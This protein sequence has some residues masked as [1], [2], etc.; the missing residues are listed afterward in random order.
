MNEVCPREQVL[1]PGS[2]VS[3]GAGLPLWLAQEPRHGRATLG[4]RQLA[5]CCESTRAP[6]GRESVGASQRPPWDI[7]ALSPTSSLGWAAGWAGCAHGFGFF[8]EDQ[9]MTVVQIKALLS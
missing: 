1:W 5:P 6:R 2:Q 9:Y 3:T 7:T 4:D 8:S